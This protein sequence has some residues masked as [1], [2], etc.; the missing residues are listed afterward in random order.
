MVTIIFTF[1]YL[2]PRDFPYRN[3]YAFAFPCIFRSRYVIVFWWLQYQIGLVFTDES[4]NFWIQCLWPTALMPAFSETNCD[5]MEYL[6]LSVQNKCLAFISLQTEVSGASIRFPS[7]CNSIFKCR[8][9]IT[10][11]N[12]RL[13][14]SRSNPPTTKVL[15][16]LKWIQSPFV[17]PREVN[18]MV[19]Q[20][21]PTANNS[22]NP[23]R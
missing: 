2:L 12:C 8:P 15:K 10:E 21:E 14:A 11:S 5:H 20:L 1:G 3:L 16:W 9:G 4:N 7:E 18:R 6:N 13:L 22:P 23:I 17:T 19:G